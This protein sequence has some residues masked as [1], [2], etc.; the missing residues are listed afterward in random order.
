MCKGTTDAKDI[1]GSVV[2]QPCLNEIGLSDDSLLVA[3]TWNFNCNQLLLWHGPQQACQRQLGYLDNTVILQWVQQ[4][5]THFGGNHGQVTIFGESAG[6]KNVSS[7]IVSPMSQGLFHG[8]IMKSGVSL[9][10]A[11]ISNTSEVYTV[12]ALYHAFLSLATQTLYIST[13]VF[14]SVEKNKDQRKFLIC[15]SF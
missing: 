15:I 8:A 5:I 7:H 1:P 12:S 6:D 11:L 14:C 10:P 3:D 4:N 2:L 9:L 13:L